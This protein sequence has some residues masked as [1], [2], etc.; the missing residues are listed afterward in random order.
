LKPR[1]KKVGKGLVLGEGRKLPEMK[2]G[3]SKKKIAE[4]N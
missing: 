4:N 2:T 3:E 1:G